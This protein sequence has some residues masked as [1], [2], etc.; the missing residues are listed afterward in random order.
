MVALYAGAPLYDY[1]TVIFDNMTRA[2]KEDR[3][4]NLLTFN[5]EYDLDV[6]ETDAVKYRASLGHKA[7]HRFGGNTKFCFVK[8]PR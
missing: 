5:K 3:H 2:Q 1:S 4:K 6:F 8:S 7:N